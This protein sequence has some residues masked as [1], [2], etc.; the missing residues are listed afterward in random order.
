MLH[1]VGI[2]QF[3]CPENVREEIADQLGEYIVSPG[4]QLEICYFKG[5][6]CV[7][8]QNASAT[9]KGGGVASAKRTQILDMLHT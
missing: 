9:D 6:K 7:W 1:I 2:Q 3:S 5:N 8:V 4:S